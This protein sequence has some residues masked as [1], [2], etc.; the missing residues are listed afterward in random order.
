[1]LFFKKSK[2]KETSSTLKKE[3]I[4][5]PDKSELIKEAENLLSSIDSAAGDERIKILNKVGSLYFKADK[6]D[7]AIKYYEVSISENKALGKAYMDLVKL[8]NIKL[9]EATNE[10]NDKNMKYYMD[11]IDNLLQLS[12]DVI[13]GRI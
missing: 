6:T 3:N 7:D 1:M 9:K 11:K 10:K 12:K 2:I 5:E 8:Y 4:K 13:R